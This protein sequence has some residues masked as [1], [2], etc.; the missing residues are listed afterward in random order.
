MRLQLSTLTLGLALALSAGAAAQPCPFAAPA[1]DGTCANVRNKQELRSV[2]EL[3]AQGG[4][5]ST[6]FDVWRKDLCVPTTTVVG[7]E[8]VDGQTI[9]IYQAQ[10]LS[11]RTYVYPD[12]QNG[13]QTWCYP[14]PTL[15][16]RKAAQ[17]GGTGDSLAILLKNS[18]TPSSDSAC[19]SACPTG[20]VCN[21]ADLQQLIQSCGANSSGPNCC[22]V[23]DLTQ[24]AP[25]CFH[26]NNT[27]NLHF[28]GSHA[29][30]QPPQ[31]YVLLE[32]RPLGADTSAHSAHGG[33]IAYGQYQYRVDPFRWTQPEGSHWYHPHKHGSVSLQ[34]ANGMPGALIIE[35]P[36]DDWLRGFYSGKLAEKLLVLQQ[37][38][39]KNNLF[40]SN[41]SAPQVL[42]N[43]Q[44]SPKVTMKPGEVQRW[45]IVNATIK[46]GSQL[47]I[48]FPQ[49][50][51]VRQIAM[52]GVRF[53]P[54]NYQCQPLYN[55]VAGPPCNLTPVG[56]PAITI[57]PGNRADFLVQAPLTEGTF[58]V[59]R[60][61]VGNLG[62]RVR[63]KV[64][65]RDDALAPDAE[66]PPLVSL[67]VDDGVDG[68]A[69]P[70]ALTA[71]APN[72]PT[73]QQW[74]PMPDY[75]T[76]IAPAEIVPPSVD[77][78]FQQTQVGSSQ[79][80]A[81]GSPLTQ[82]KINGLQYNS[83][84]VNITTQLGKA[85]EWN[86]SNVTSLNHPFHIHT[87]P[88]QVVR[89]AAVTYPDPI[90]Q[91]TIGLPRG[92]TAAPGS[93]LLRQRYEEFTGEYVLHCHFLGH[94]DRGMMFGVQTT[95]ADNAA[96]YGT[97]NA[98]GQPECPPKSPNPAGP[99]CPSISTAGGGR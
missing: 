56:T 28:H 49:G 99:Q 74:P 72:F 19:D 69:G 57:W 88:F 35:G 68:K 15:R 39:Q 80:G 38:E 33:E 6:T 64:F 10:R 82:F 26:G 75:L 32:L 78:V 87:N 58:A 24:T 44:V 43:G 45:R 77:L 27:T 93:V 84:C 94:E 14:G 34:V 53:S 73:P 98:G 51:L 52:D 76:N 62:E 3:V 20:T 40:D 36:F 70:L 9:T 85:K 83:D 95:C 37:V 54:L 18:L 50:T 71:A 41:A 92:T 91:D 59:E 81:Q 7:T 31:D 55:P 22:C 79:P 23:I 46:A 89:N 67:Q 86:V 11:L 13:Q 1:A 2:P 12:P 47:A 60:K 66:E 21:P 5:L 29:S 97:P 65:A 17:A 16:L 63:A 48:Y 25:N 42:V 8:Q 4:T 96:T 61:V 90:W 30:P